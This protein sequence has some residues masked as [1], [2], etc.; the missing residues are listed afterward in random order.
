M[1][2]IKNIKL[3]IVTDIKI[4]IKI[5]GE[6]KTKGITMSCGYI[7]QFI[8]SPPEY[9]K[10]IICTNVLR[11]P[12]QI[13]RCGHHYCSTCFEQLKSYANHLATPLL[14]PVDRKEVDL[15]TVFNDTAMTRIIADLVV[16]CSF[17]TNGCEW[18]GELRDLEGHKSRCVFAPKPTAPVEDNALIKNILKRVENCEHN[19]LE[20]EK[21]IAHLKHN[22][23][24]MR[25]SAGVTDRECKLLREKNV[26]MEVEIVALKKRDTALQKNIDEIMD[27]CEENHQVVNNKLVQVESMKVEVKEQTELIKKKVEEM[28][29]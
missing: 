6:I 20:K 17:H 28:E 10:C 9:M 8:D 21:E 24:E 19:L 13:M 26:Q 3:H 5:K 4:L 29:G 7:E 18:S 27:K 12:V 15:S 2:Q 11:D 23:D 1:G 25:R 14:C 16:K 22:I